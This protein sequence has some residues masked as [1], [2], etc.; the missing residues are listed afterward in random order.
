MHWWSRFDLD[1]ARADLARL[2][3]ARFG[4]M[5]FFLRWEDFQPAAGV[6]DDSAL[7][8][9]EQFA[10]AAAEIGVRLQPTLF[11]GHMSGANWLPA[12][13]TVPSRQRQRFPVITGGCVV[14]DRAPANF[15][16]QE[17]LIRAQELLA[18]EVARVLARHPALWSWDL[19][20]EHSIMCVPAPID[21]GRRWL[22]GMVEAR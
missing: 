21:Q 15:Y 19:G 4:A 16:E 7:R 18:R 9:L 2:A 14:P 8:H 5:R 12:F 20:N 11:T 3:D 17:P 10:D 1:A 22:A 13:A 6:V